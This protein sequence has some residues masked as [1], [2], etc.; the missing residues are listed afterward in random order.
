MSRNCRITVVILKNMCYNVIK[1]QIVLAFLRILSI[2]KQT[3]YRKHTRKMSFHT[4][5]LSKVLTLIIFLQ[6][7]GL[8]KTKK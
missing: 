7:M 3:L 6:P 4:I 8:Y 5:V 1:Y 2:L